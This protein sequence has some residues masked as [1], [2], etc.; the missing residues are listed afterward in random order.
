MVKYIFLGVALLGVYAVT[1]AA[2]QSG[3][4]YAGYGMQ[5]E[6][7]RYTYR[8]GPSFWYFGGPRYYGSEYYGSGRGIS[9][10]TAAPSGGSVRSG[11]LGGSG[12]FGG[13]PGAGK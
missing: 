8:S 11:S 7:D 5:R 10:R 2:S 1:F 12:F 6:N 13:G 4:G 3:Y 9:R